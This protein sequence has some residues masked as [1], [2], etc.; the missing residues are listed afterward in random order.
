[1]AKTILAKQFDG[2]VIP[3]ELARLLQAFHLNPG[4]DTALDLVLFDP[5]FSAVFELCRSGGFTEQL[6]KK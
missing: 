4:I 2:S 5:N 6:Y 3:N 1:M